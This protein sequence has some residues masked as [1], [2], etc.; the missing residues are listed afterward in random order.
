MGGGTVENESCGETQRMDRSEILHR[1][2]SP[3]GSSNYKKKTKG[4]KG[5]GG[6]L[7]IQ[8]WRGTS[9][10]GLLSKAFCNQTGLG[11]GGKSQK[12]Q[13]REKHRSWEKKTRKGGRKTAG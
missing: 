4:G 6:K 8:Q 11:Q 3:G 13:E 10:L 2:T 5:G 9:L 12:K 7:K 1:G